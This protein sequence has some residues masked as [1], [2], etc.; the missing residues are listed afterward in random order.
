MFS[1]IFM[2]NVGSV[3]EIGFFIHIKKLVINDA[4][5]CKNPHTILIKIPKSRTR[6]NE[7]IALLLM[8]YL[9]MSQVPNSMCFNCWRR[10]H[11]SKLVF[12]SRFTAGIWAVSGN[13][14]KKTRDVLLTK[15]I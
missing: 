15:I 10:V 9:V 4:V 3:Y 12:K 7:Y 14:L 2:R 8:V 5:R 6:F 13:C 11:N 1:S